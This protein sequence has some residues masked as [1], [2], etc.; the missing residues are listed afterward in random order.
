MDIFWNNSIWIQLL[1]FLSFT[2]I[3]NPVGLIHGQISPRHLKVLNTYL[4][5]YGKEYVYSG[6]NDMSTG[7]TVGGGAPP[8]LDVNLQSHHLITG[9]SLRPCIGICPLPLVF[10]VVMWNNS[11]SWTYLKYNTKDGLRT[12]CRTLYFVTHLLFSEYIK[13]WL[14]C[15]LKKYILTLEQQK[16]IS[17]HKSG[18]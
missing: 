11:D 9:I 15:N 17:T 14:L 7:W 1:W 10:R 13:L 6:L 8:Q 3:R 12:V 16:N 5:L 2:D 18:L 4:V